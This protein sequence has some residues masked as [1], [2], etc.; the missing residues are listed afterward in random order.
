M[1]LSLIN[2]RSFQ[3]TPPTSVAKFSKNILKNLTNAGYLTYQAVK[4]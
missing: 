1:Y 4:I 3:E 2:F